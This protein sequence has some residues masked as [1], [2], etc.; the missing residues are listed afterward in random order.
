MAL[1]SKLFHWMTDRLTDRPTDW[2][3]QWSGNLFCGSEFRQLK[4]NSHS[5][6]VSVCCKT[7]WIG[8]GYW[9]PSHGPLRYVR[10]ILMLSSVWE[11]SI[12]NNPEMAFMGM[13]IRNI[14]ICLPHK[15]EAP[16]IDL[17]Y[18]IIWQRGDNS[19]PLLSVEW[20][21]GR[22]SGGVWI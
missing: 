14:Q 19:F 9:I 10:I 15:Q 1:C 20:V 3:E 2:I 13:M 4:L 6:S 12:N 7:G 18:V 17:Q 11:T 8:I 16:L 21:G 22:Q 5:F